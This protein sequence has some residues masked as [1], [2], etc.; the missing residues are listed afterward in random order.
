[1]KEIIVKF[2]Q[3]LTDIAVQY[4]GSIDGVVNLIED[5]N[6][7]ITSIDDRI[8]AGMVLLIN[9]AKIIN[10]GIVNYF[11]AKK[12]DIGTGE[13]LIPFKSFNRS[14]SKAFH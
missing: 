12:I 11:I 3:N 9:E 6:S 4:Y 10:Q 8:E 14:F 5:N 2:N 13:D 7:Q 1:M